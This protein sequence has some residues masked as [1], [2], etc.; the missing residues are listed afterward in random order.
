MIMNEQTHT[1]TYNQTVFI[2]AERQFERFNELLGL[3]W[4]M[5]EVCLEGEEIYPGFTNIMGDLWF[6]FSALD[7]KLDLAARKRNE[8]Q[9]D[10]MARLMK[11]D[12]YLRTHTLTAADD[13]LSVLTAVLMGERLRDWLMSDAD[14]QEA[15]LKKLRAEW[16]EGNARRQMDELHQSEHASEA[17]EQEKNRAGLHRKF[18]NKQLAYA[19]QDQQQAEKGL[20]DALGKMTAQEL[21]GILADTR[22]EAK[23]TKHAVLEIATLNGKKTEQ[24]PMSEQFQLAQKIQQHDTLKRI[25]EMTGRFKQIARKKTRTK[26]HETQERKDVTLGQEVSRLLPAEIAN[27]IMPDSKLD[28]LRRYAEQQ[29]FVFD[30]KGNSKGRG[31]II[32]CMDE[33]SS[34]TPIMEESKAFCLALLMIAH[35]QKRD[36]AIIPFAS[37]IGK[38]LIF[39][40][41]RSTADDILDFSNRFLGGG[42]NYEKPLRASLDILDRSEFN[43]ADILFVTDGSSFLSSRFLEE[44][45][46]MKKKRKF[47]CTSIVLTNLINTVN[48]E[49][50]QSFSD[51]VIEV[52]ELFEA[53][54]AFSFY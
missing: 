11:T 2:P 54:E 8:I 29:T 51:K 28:F 6:A 49:L 52:N 3:A 16:T 39:P 44:F 22:E 15:R 47:E 10:V 40:K 23:N 26:H 41:G 30:T 20:H 7:P 9:Y 18:V 53:E 25:A 14:V 36:F 13:L 37:D 32:I 19:R 48:M 38:V 35:R 21:G 1:A 27:F 4:I 45:N 17:G 46:A 34:M 42:T 24:L 33:S 50:V 5:E 43:E 12:E 31:P